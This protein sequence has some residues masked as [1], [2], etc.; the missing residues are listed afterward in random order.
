MN[1]QLAHRSF[2]TS[3][4]HPV[5]GEVSYP[6]LPMTVTLADDATI[7]TGHRSPAPLLA[8]HDDV[9]ETVLGVSAERAKQL[10]D[11]GVCGAPRGTSSRPM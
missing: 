2:Y 11:I 1:P 3:L 9:V 6:G 10:R 7:P 4:D 8:Q 5:C